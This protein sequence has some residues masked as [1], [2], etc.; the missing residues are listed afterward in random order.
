MIAS[1]HSDHNCLFGVNNSRYSHSLIQ[2]SDSISQSDDT[3]VGSVDSIETLHQAPHVFHGYECLLR[4]DFINEG[5]GFL[6]IYPGDL[7]VF[8]DDGCHL[9]EF[10]SDAN[11][12][13]NIFGINYDLVYDSVDDFID[14]NGDAS[15]DGKIYRRDQSGTWCSVLNLADKPWQGWLPLRKCNFEPFGNARSGWQHDQ[16]YSSDL[17]ESTDLFML[18]SFKPEYKRFVRQ[19]QVEGRRFRKYLGFGGFIDQH[20]ALEC[21]NFGPR[22]FNNTRPGTLAEVAAFVGQNDEYGNRIAITKLS[23]LYLFIRQFHDQLIEK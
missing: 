13:D 4:R 17:K 16:L 6:D 8:F 18:N 22:E 23:F 10:C 15:L 20:R 12:C 3:T 2:G 9:D 21:Q 11:E 7:I 14:S 1:S 19:M 5:E